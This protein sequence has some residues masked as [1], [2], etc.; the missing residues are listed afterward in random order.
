MASLY[1][2]FFAS[3]DVLLFRGDCL[4]LVDWSS[5][6]HV[7]CDD[8]LLVKVKYVVLLYLLLLQWHLLM[9]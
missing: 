5:V 2:F 3:N 8:L 9:Q 7:G 4:L 6:F 1:Y